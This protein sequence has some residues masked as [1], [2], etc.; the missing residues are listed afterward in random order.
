[1]SDTLDK[2]LQSSTVCLYEGLGLVFLIYLFS[3]FFMKLKT[4]PVIKENYDNEETPL[5]MHVKIIALPTF[6]AKAG[7]RF[8]SSGTDKIV[9][10]KLTKP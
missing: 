3:A 6:K 2:L 9:V 8:F 10:F 7:V 4:P 5:D 1:M